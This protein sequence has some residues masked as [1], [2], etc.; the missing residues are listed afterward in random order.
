MSGRAEGCVQGRA[1]PTMRGRRACRTTALPAL[2]RS[3]LRRHVSRRQVRLLRRPS[4]QMIPRSGPGAARERE[5]DEIGTARRTQDVSSTPS[6]KSSTRRMSSFGSGYGMSRICSY[7]GIAWKIR[8]PGTTQT[9]IT[10]Y[11]S[12][13][14][15]RKVEVHEAVRCAVDSERDRL[16]G[17]GEAL[18]VG[19]STRRP[20]KCVHR[21]LKAI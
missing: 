1:C 5:S 12:Q 2:G 3:C 14:V 20:G 18:D 7:T 15:E 4:R 11:L 8:Q 16:L 10:L 21:Y 13:H 19:E 6:S 17:G 9:A